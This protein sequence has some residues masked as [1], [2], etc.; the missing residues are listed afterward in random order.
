[1]NEKFN[2]YYLYSMQAKSQWRPS[3]LEISSFEN[4]RPGINPLFLSQNMAQKL[5]ANP[6]WKEGKQVK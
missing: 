4:V 5:K 6:N 1:M 3:S 2:Q